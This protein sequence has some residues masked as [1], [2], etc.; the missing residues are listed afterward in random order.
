MRMR[1]LKQFPAG[2][3]LSALVL[4][5]LLGA[6]SAI[7]PPAD[8]EI[9]Q[10]LADRVDK[11]RQSVG[12]V[13][14]VV[15]RGGRRVIAHGRLA[16]DDSRPLNGDTVFEIGSITKVFTALLLTD[17]VERGEVELTDPVA[18]HLPPTVKVPQR[19]GEQ[20][21]LRDLA[22]HLSSLP[23]MPSNVDSTDASN[24][25]ADYSVDRLYNFLSGYVLP[26]DI[27][28]RFEYSNIGGALLA[29]ALAGRSGLDYEDLVE[30]RIARP[31]GLRSTRIDV[32]P[33]MKSRLAVGHAYGLLPTPNWALGALEGAG[34]L[35]STAN[36]LL[37]FL[38]AHLG[39]TKTPLAPAMASMLRFRR[40]IGQGEVGLA[41]FSRVHDGVEII[42]HE[43]S[44]GG[45]RTFIGYD[46]KARVGVVV[47]SN[48]GTGAG[49]YDIGVHLLN[50]STPLLSEDEL[51][52]PKVRT[53]VAVDTR[54]LDRYA[55]RYQFPSRQ[56]AQVT[57]EGD[58]LLLQGEG[59]VKIA[60]FAESSR[61]F[62]AKIMDAQ[63]TFESDTQGNIT[64]LLFHRSGAVQQVRRSE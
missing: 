5:P 37:T 47:L 19:N 22:M 7:R 3:V 38:A 26:R 58:H 24:P 31:L 2:L 13:V 45:Y 21:T 20:I 28:S 17:M 51:K 30:T 59:D 11:Y 55:G 56:M 10:I 6:Q 1:A 12:I 43:G 29:H 14:G 36:D 50:P 41:W 53:E 32:N 23:R 64:G 34:A 42:S 48:T 39:Y 52:P 9:L 25:F 40:S 49:I 16:A 60:F 27:G 15:E 18:T 62:F 54:L 44:T 4:A 46:P 57:R 33:E 8:S 61:D 63:I 35:H